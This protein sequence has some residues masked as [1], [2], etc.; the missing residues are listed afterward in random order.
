M[1]KKLL[2]KNDHIPNIRSYEV[3]RANGGYTAVEK[4]LK[5]MTPE[6][7][8]EEVKNPAYVVG[9]AQVFLPG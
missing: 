1:S 3:Y 9:V 8:V 4:A 5:T 7:I 2:L 6:V